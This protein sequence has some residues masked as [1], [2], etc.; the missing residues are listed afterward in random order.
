M[1]AL[2][3]EN[4]VSYMFYLPTPKTPLFD[5]ALE[6]GFEA[7]K[8]LEAWSQFAFNLKDINVPWISSDLKRFIT[9]LVQIYL[10][11]AYPPAHRQALWDGRRLAPAYRLMQEWARFRIRTGTYAF[12][13]EPVLV[14]WLHTRP[15]TL[16][17]A[18]RK[19][20]SAARRRLP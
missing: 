17:R 8:D 14:D 19:W 13:V 18:G 5:L 10:V 3:P 1:R 20:L 9:A 2:S 4:I 16:Y 12:P 6:H 7:P 15:L 11:L